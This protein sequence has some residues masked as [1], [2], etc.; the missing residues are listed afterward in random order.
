MDTSTE[1]NSNS[2]I[3]YYSQAIDPRQSLYHRG[4]H[5]VL[6]RMESDGEIDEFGAYTVG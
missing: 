2:V 1:I 3:S 6:K 4:H 5:T